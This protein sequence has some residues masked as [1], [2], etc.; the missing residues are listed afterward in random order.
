MGIVYRAR[1][2]SL[3]RIVA[4]KMILSGQLASDEEVKRFRVEAEAAANLQHSN[5]V[6]I[7][8][9][10][11]HQGQHYFSMDFIEGK[12]LAA[13]CVTRFAPAECLSPRSPA[14]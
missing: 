6:A 14:A 2:V 1:Q 7:H 4:V 3:N 12:N 13:R 8:E 11:E 5:I 9:I 10:G